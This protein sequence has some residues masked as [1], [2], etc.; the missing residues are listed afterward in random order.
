MS[1]GPAVFNILCSKVTRLLTGLVQLT[2]YLGR[3]DFVD[4]VTGS[5]PVDGVVCLDREFLNDKRV[6]VQLVCCFRYGREDEETMGL[7]FK[8]ELMLA[9][10]LLN[11]FECFSMKYQC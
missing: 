4:H 7:N 3:R 10:V 5:D 1:C 9:E 6:S 11:L 8:K 2:L